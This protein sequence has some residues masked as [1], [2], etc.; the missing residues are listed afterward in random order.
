MTWHTLMH[1][2]ATAERLL[3]RVYVFAARRAMG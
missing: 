1:L 3:N 2:A